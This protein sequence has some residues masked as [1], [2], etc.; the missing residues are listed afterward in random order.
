VALISSQPWR[1]QPSG[2]A[3]TNVW[4]PDYLWNPAI[5]TQLQGR[6]VAPQPSVFTGQRRVNAAGIAYAYNGTT[7]Y[8]NWIVNAGVSAF[9]LVLASSFVCVDTLVSNQPAFAVGGSIEGGGILAGVGQY[10]SG[11]VG[12]WLR[13]QN[14][15]DQTVIDGPAAVAGKTYNVIRISRSQTNH[16][17]YVNG[18]EYTSSTDT[19]PP[20]DSWKNLTSGCVIRD[21]APLWYGYQTVNQGFF[22]L[23]HCPADAWAREWSKNPFIVYGS[24]RIVI[25]TSSTTLPALS[26]A[27]YVPG[28][29]TS[30]GFRPRVTAS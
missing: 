24:R 6:R 29:I 25:P 27:T 4:V 14:S 17:M 2:I 8:N 11:F 21:T 22:A 19:G 3:R 30:S 1:K 20:S 12:S 9:P 15:G 18:V 28:S 7:Q 26:A 23:G 13:A 5:G 10:S 16:V